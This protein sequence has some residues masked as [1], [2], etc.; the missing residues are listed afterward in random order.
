MLKT[1]KVRNY[2]NFKGELVL[3]FGEVGGY[4]FSQDCITDNVISKMIIYGKNATGKTNLGE[5]LLDITTNFRD[6]IFWGNIDYSYVN[7]DTTDKEVDFFYE[8]VL[9]GKR[10]IYEYSK[11]AQDI[12][13]EE[14][15]FIEE[16]CVFE[17]NFDKKEV[18]INHL[19]LVD[20]ESVIISK[21]IDAL[22]NQNEEIGMRTLPFIRWLIAN[23]ALEAD[24]ILLKLSD[25][26]SRMTIISVGSFTNFRRF[27]YDKFFQL[28]A[29][30]HQ[31][32]DFEDFLNK[33]GIE[34]ELYLEENLDGTYLLYFKHE[35]GLI[36]FVRNASSG[37]LALV[38]LYQ[39]LVSVRR[40]S[41]LY[42]DEFDA[43]Y[44]YELAENVV[45]ILKAKYPECQIVL[46]SHNTNLM[47]NRILRPDC[48]LILSRYGLTPLSRATERE[49][50]EG[51]NLEK[52][53]I[54]GEFSKYE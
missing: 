29:E 12:M 43:F 33:M 22:Q 37:T 9:G 21:Y 1:F 41:F 20:A 11:Y 38:R 15:L 36:P 19:A 8:F 47:T 51:H 45:K 30:N 14:K 48:L 10:L 7:A 49:L 50:R 44:N 52:M 39:N 3:N 35:N 24:N 25:Y 54:G 31:L 5:A 26:V 13:K 34:C 42:M 16:E 2:K 6:M 4:K 18:V 23:T 46:T 27:H 32:N 40:S 53:Y 28:L 17:V